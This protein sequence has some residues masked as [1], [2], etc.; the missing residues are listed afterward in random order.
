MPAAK[1]PGKEYQNRPRLVPR[2]G[3]LRIFPIGQKRRWFTDIY[4]YLM[5]A[6]W[7][8]LL[9][10]IAFLYL[11]ANLMFASG[12]LALGNGIENARPGSF[13]D[14]FFFSVQTMATIGYGHLIP[15]G[16]IANV[17]VTAEA[18]FGFGYFAMVTGLAFS[19]FSRPTARVLFSEVAV[20]SPHDGALHLKMRL[21]NQRANGIVN[22][23][24]TM[25][26]LRT[27]TN[28]E[29]QRLRRFS[30]LK[31]ERDF[32]PLL[33]LTWTPLHKIDETS[34]LFGETYESLAAGDAEIVVSLTGLDES[35]GQTIHARYSYIPDEIVMHAQF[36]DIIE[37]RPDQGLGIRYDKF[38]NVLDI[39]EENKNAA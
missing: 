20:I 35:F 12:Y 13:E 28:Q 22:A 23:R 39:M 29:G 10:L 25:V 14:A 30:D 19:K 5:D 31:L 8:E 16:F 1:P 33:R 26:L 6:P 17:L 36:E 15:V 4:P 11:S 34:P 9:A 32:V 7:Y 38:H 21:A 18:L 24:L 27:V 37:M 2:A 3:K